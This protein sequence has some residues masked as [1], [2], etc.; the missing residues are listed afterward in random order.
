LETLLFD[1]I[2]RK[3][4]E[5]GARVFAINAVADH[6]HL[7][8]SAPT[9][10]SIAIFTKHVKGASVHYINTSAVTQDAYIAWQPGYGL[11]TFTRR[12]LPRVV[13]YV[14]YQKQQQPSGARSW[15]ALNARTQI[16]SRNHAAF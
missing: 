4:A 11:L 9:R 2:G 1:Y 14:K 12:D 6:V 8:C 5:L 3:C 13:D 7:A 16:H 10:L 15:P